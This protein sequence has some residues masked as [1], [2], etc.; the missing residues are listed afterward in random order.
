MTRSRRHYD[1]PSMKS[2][3]KWCRQAGIDVVQD[4]A[5]LVIGD[6]I[7]LCPIT[8]AI[9][10]MGDITSKT[11]RI[12]GAVTR[13]L[14]TSDD[15]KLMWVV[16][17]QKFDLA[18]GVALQV[19]NPW[20]QND[21]ASQDIM[22]FGFLSTPPIVLDSADVQEVNRESIAFD[23]HVKAMRKLDRNTH[24]VVLTFASSAGGDPDGVFSI[25]WA[26]SLLM[27]WSR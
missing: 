27:T 23:M 1:S 5:N 4:E 12:T 20:N 3:T 10:T 18:T 11:V 13:A 19:I 7:T 25:R 6:G 9:D 17:L 2:P 15:I 22:G 26:T 21:L 24:T 14:A 8:T 16:A